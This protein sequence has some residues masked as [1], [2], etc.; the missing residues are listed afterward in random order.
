MKDDRGLIMQ[1]LLIAGIVLAAVVCM[2]CGCGKREKP[3]LVVG[4]DSLTLSKIRSLI[5]DTCSDSAKLRQIRLRL[6]LARQAKAV[7][8]PEADSASTRLARRLTLLSGK[9]WSPEAAAVLLDAGKALA[10]QRATARDPQRLAALVELLTAASGKTVDQK[11]L[12]GVSGGD[13]LRGSDAALFSTIFKISEEEAATLLNFIGKKTRDKPADAAGMVRRLLSP[14]EPETKMTAAQGDRMITAE[15]VAIENPAL[16]LR[17]RPQGSI[18]DSIEKRRVDLQQLYKRQLKTN[19]SAGGTVWLVFRV[20]AE[21][22]VFSVSVKSSDIG[23]RA[24]LQ[25]LQEYARTIRFKAIP[26][27]VGNMTF[28]FPFEFTSES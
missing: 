16:A 28:E 25:Q 18:R 1:R 4:S 17:F 5:P 23:N 21:G 12:A 6:A 9:E 15:R 2:F 19:E 11:T 7:R 26:K 22:K 13:T 20:D 14:Q 27:D 8:T 24:F 3:A 10:A